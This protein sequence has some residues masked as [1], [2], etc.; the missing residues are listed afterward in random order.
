MD[1]KYLT[2]VNEMM[3]MSEFEELKDSEVLY[4]QCK[5]FY[6]LAE[7]FLGDDHVSFIADHSNGEAE[8]NLRKLEFAHE[9]IKYSPEVSFSLKEAILKANALR[10]RHMEIEEEEDKVEAYLEQLDQEEDVIK[11]ALSEMGLVAEEEEDEEPEVYSANDFH[12]E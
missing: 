4:V 5:D 1:K 12:G 9:L 2:E 11:Q 8:D 3:V 6:K 7:M 10:K